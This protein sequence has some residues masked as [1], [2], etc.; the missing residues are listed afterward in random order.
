MDNKLM[1]KFISFLIEH[2]FYSVPLLVV[3]I[4]LIRSHAIKGGKKITPQELINL[5]NQDAAQLI[6]LRSS[7]EFNDGH[8]TGSINIPYS[9]IEDRIHEIKKQEGKSLV[10]ICDTGSQS[11]N[12]GEVLNKSGFENTVILSGG[13]G[14]WRLDNLPLV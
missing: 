1:D 9:D 2:Y 3:L 6:D 8:I 13:I 7:S 4:L 10:L 12:A 5:T 11:A 14:A